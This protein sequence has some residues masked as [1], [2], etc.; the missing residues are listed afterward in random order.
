[1]DKSLLQQQ[2]C[3]RLAD[4]LAL[5]LAAAEAALHPATHEHSKAENND[6]TPGRE[7]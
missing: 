2:V 1:M 5:L 3:R 6:E 4:E 7:D